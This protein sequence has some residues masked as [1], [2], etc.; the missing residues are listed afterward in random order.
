M[1][2]IFYKLLEFDNFSPLYGDTVN[3]PENTI[4][5]RGYSTEF[6]TISDRPAYFGSL[7]NAKS[8]LKNNKSRLGAFTNK[9]P[10]RLLEYHFM[11]AILKQFIEEI[12]KSTKLA[13]EEADVICS[14]IVSF[15][16]CSLEHQ[17][18]LLKNNYSP[19][20]MNYVPGF[21][22]VIDSYKTPGLIEQ[23]GIRIGETTNDAAT[24]GFLRN[25]FKQNFDGFISP[26][27]KTPFHTEKSGVLPPEMVL[28]NPLGSGIQQINAIPKQIPLIS[29]NDLI[30]RSTIHVRLFIKDVST[31]FYMKGGSRRNK[32]HILDE[33]E[34][35]IQKNTKSIVDNYNKG[36]RVGEEWSK[37]DTNIHYWTPPVPHVRGID[38]MKP[39]AGALTIN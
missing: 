3:I 6:P 27:L 16:L 26:E 39:V 29:I 21:K 7:M 34:E 28:F 5:F 13:Q 1:Q 25:L 33:I 11:K 22:R 17:I 30:N 38:I 31:N 37:K 15:G 20:Y 35:N 4:F 19:A 8:Y 23:S 14:V 12:T 24:M 18:R 36:L 2:P 9:K 32:R 10:L